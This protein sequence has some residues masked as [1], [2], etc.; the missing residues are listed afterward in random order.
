M[1]SLEVQTAS[2]QEGGEQT[3]RW[4]T[5]ERFTLHV[6]RTVDRL[7]QDWPVMIAKFLRMVGIQVNWFMEQV[8][9]DSAF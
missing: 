6:L 9:N 7:R 2:W 1:E 8:E 3:G 4:S 5:G